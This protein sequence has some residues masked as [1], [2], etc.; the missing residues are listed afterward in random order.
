M[1]KAEILVW[2]LELASQVNVRR[3]V[4]ASLLPSDHALSG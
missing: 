3:D 2:A 1:E 4:L